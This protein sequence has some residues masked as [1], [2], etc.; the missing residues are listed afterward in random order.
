LSDLTQM[1]EQALQKRKALLES[2]QAEN[3]NCYRLFQGSSEGYPGLTIDRYGPQL[4]IQSFHSPL[5]SEILAEITAVS[6]TH[7]LP[8]EVVYND[9]SAA[10]SRRSDS[11]QISQNKHICQEL[12]LNYLVKGKHAGQDPL[13]FLDLRVGRRYVLAHAAG[14]S[15]LNLCAYTCGLGLCAAQ[16]GAKEVWNLDFSARY[17]D[18]GLENAR[19]NKLADDSQH[20]LQSDFFTAVK[21][22]AGLPITFRKGKGVESRTYPKLEPRQ[23]DLVCLD[24]PRWSKGPFGNID[25]VRD[26][27]SVFK[28]ALLATRAGGTLLCTNNVAEVK[29]QEWADVLM[30]CANKAGRPIESLEWLTP[31][32]DFPSWDGQHPLKIAVLKV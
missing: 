24:P 19:L 13:L 10:Y 16:A 2:L 3:T 31:E 21:Q 26:Y 27:Q 8:Q 29:R 11:D 14:L 17:L 7:F 12:G 9:R 5:S 32:A 18:I 28:P 30:R 4:L 25:L 23:F 22:W 15:V 20:F 1:L 6:Q